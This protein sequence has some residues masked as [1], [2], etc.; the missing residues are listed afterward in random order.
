MYYLF[1]DGRVDEKQQMGKFGEYLTS[2]QLFISLTKA[3][4]GHNFASIKK[5]LSGLLGKHAEDNRAFFKQLVYYLNTDVPATSD[6]DLED[7]KTMIIG[8]IDLLT[9]IG[10][11]M[12]KRKHIKT[13]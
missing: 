9:V 4:A 8:A 12:G 1:I 10:D 6:W 13:I 5:E 3:L 11:E 7:L 2:E